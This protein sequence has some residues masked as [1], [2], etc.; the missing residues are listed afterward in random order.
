M[1]KHRQL[2]AVAPSGPGGPPRFAAGAAV[3]V[4]P[5]VR[6][7]DY[8]DIPLG[9]WAGQVLEVDG[10]NQPPLYLV[11]WNARTMAEVH[12]IYRQRTEND[13][14]E[15]DTLWLDETRL[16]PDN[17]P[18]GPMEQPAA[19]VPRPL[20]AHQQA[21]RIRAILGLTS[22]DPLPAAGKEPLR[23]YHQFLRENLSLPCN[24]EVWLQSG[25]VQGKTH[26]VTV[27]RL[28]DLEEGT[29]ES[30]GLLV[31]AGCGQER[32]V[33]PLAAL[34]TTADSPNRRLIQ[35]YVC[36]FVEGGQEPAGPDEEDDEDMTGPQAAWALL[37]RSVVYGMG[38]GAVLGALLATQDAAGFHGMYIGAGLLAVVGWLV[39]VRRG[40]TYGAAHRVKG[41]PLLGGVLGVALGGLA[42]AAG[43][44][45]VVG[46]LGTVPGSIAGN[47][48][49]KLA[50][51]LGWKPVGEP[52]WTLLGACAGGM[53]LALC[54]DSNRALAG[55][56]AGVLLGG[57]MTAL[58]FL[59]VVVA[60]G[61]MMN[62]QE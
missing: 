53:V 9:G 37:L 20:R 35:D 14:Y 55:A 43:G 8:P 62:A 24:A 4:K 28:L 18:A 3:R 16:E 32:M 52:I 1:K 11:Q 34:E 42:G 40:L 31:E 45:M 27:Y 21:D 22:D 2:P 58:V 54:L 47:L 15:S 59:L 60:L 36:W 10:N 13:G 39:G 7:S 56:M 50:A 30:N 23:K 33:L 17:D 6:D 29:A 61:L 57:V 49:G 41:G 5:G 19:I 51:W 25:P 44:I 38:L 26:L 12:P 48:L 46:Y